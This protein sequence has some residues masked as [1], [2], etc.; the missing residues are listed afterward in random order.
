MTGEK[1]F[2][3]RFMEAFGLEFPKDADRS[4]E[5]L[6]KF[7]DGGGTIG[8]LFD[9]V[10]EAFPEKKDRILSLPIYTGID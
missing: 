8:K 2:I 5:I 10:M 4:V 3:R 9:D 1:Y 6:E 7:D